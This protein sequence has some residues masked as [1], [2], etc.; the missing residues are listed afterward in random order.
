MHSSPVLQ[1]SRAALGCFPLLNGG[2]GDPKGALLY[3][4]LFSSRVGLHGRFVAVGETSPKGRSVLFTLP[5]T[6]P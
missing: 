6:Q 4:N 3:G 2:G 1:L 5:Q